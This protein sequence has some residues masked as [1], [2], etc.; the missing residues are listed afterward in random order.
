MVRRLSADARKMLLTSAA[1]E[2]R[3]RGDRRL[4]TEHLLLGLLHDAGSPPARALGVSLEAARAASGDLDLAALAAVGIRVEH[5]GRAPEPL[6][7][8]RGGGMNRRGV[9]YDAGRV[10]WGQDWRPDFSP[11]EMHRELE[12]IKNDLH[13][14]A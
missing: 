5:A 11:V 13:C 2:A 10:M 1:G 9:C 7:A 4:G 6:P 14:N 12:I 8:R 3:R